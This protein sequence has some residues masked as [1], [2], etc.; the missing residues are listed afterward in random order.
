MGDTVIIGADKVIRA[1]ANMTPEINKK[2]K[3]AVLKAGAM[4]KVEWQNEITS[5]GAIDTGRYRGSIVSKPDMTLTVL[6]AN[7]STDVDYATHVEWGT[8]YMPARP[9]MR[10]AHAKME[11]KFLRIVSEAVAKAIKNA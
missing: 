6:A 1:L 8:K 4:T 11:G 10:S 2:V 7:V 9:A 3:G 5:M